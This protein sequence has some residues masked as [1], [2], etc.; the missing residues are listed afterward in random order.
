MMPETAA[1]RGHAATPLN[2]APQSLYDWGAMA[3]EA[4][5]ATSQGVEHRYG[6]NCVATILDQFLNDLS[7]L[8][9]VSLSRVLSIGQQMRRICGVSFHQQRT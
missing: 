9:D 1:C 8:G 4:V 6:Q 5:E 3:L 7:L 2:Y